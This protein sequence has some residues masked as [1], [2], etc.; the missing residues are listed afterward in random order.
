VLIKFQLDAAGD[1][2]ASARQAMMT[3]LNLTNPMTYVVRMFPNPET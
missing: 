1:M 3:N 2:H